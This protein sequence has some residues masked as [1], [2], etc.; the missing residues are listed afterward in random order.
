MPSQLMN[1]RMTGLRMRPISSFAVIIIQNSVTRRRVTAVTAVR[2]YSRN[3]V[4]YEVRSGS[5]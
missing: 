2:P 4:R 1:A 5:S 3:R